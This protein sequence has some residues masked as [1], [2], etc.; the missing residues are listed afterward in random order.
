L[1]GLR[2]EHAGLFY[3][4]LEYFT[5]IWY[6]LWPFGIVVVICYIFPSSILCEE[7]SGNPGGELNPIVLNCFEFS[8]SARVRVGEG[9]LALRKKKLEEKKRQS[10]TKSAFFPGK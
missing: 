9:R 7:K 5:I 6:I 10:L 4:H 2:L 3:G 1:E 8:F